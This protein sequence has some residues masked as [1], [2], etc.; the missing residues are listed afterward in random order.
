MWGRGLRHCQLSSIKV[1]GQ[2]LLN[3]TD[4]TSWQCLRR[5]TAILLQWSSS[6]VCSTI[7]SRGSKC[8]SWYLLSYSHS[9][10][11]NHF[12]IVILLLAATVVDLTACVCLHWIFLWWLTL[13][14]ESILM[15]SLANIVFVC[16][17]QTAPAISAYTRSFFS[18]WFL[19]NTYLDLFVDAPHA[20][21]RQKTWTQ[22]DI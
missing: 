16:F 21:K 13:R 22:L 19:I 2:S 17:C 7:L 15:L 1:D 14:A 20:R 9:L 18:F 3:W 5:S 8:D 12:C 6:S 4:Q 10:R 11:K